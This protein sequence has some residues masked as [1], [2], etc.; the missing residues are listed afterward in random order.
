MNIKNIFTYII[1][2]CSIIIIKNCYSQNPCFVCDSNNAGFKATAF[3]IG[4]DAQGDFSFSSGFYS[5]SIGHSSISMGAYSSAESMNAV[6][7]G[8]FCKA[9]SAGYAFGQH[10]RA[11]GEPSVAIGHYV[12]ANTSRSIVIGSCYSDNRLINDRHN[13]LMVGFLSSYPTLFVGPTEQGQDFG[14]VGIGTKDPYTT[15]DV[16]GGVL[17]K[18]FIYPTG[19]AHEG[20]VLKSDEFGKADWA[21]ESPSL[22]TECLIG[23]G[24]YRKEGNVGI[25]NENPL[26]KLML[27]H[28]WTFNINDLE[29]NQIGYNTLF[30]GGKY[31]RLSSG[32]GSL[33]SFEPSG[34]ISIQHV[35]A[36][37]VGQQVDP[38][39]AVIFESTGNVGIGTRTPE[40]KLDV[41]G[42]IK[43]N[44]FQLL[45]ETIEQGFVLRSNYD[46]TAYWSNPDDLDDGDWYV[47]DNVLWVDNKKIGLGNSNPSEK[48]HIDGN[49]AITGDIL[50]Y[51]TS[52]KP[53]GIYSGS[54]SDDGASITLASNYDNTGSIK[55]FCKGDNGRIEFHNKEGQVM[56]LRA[57]NNVVLGS[58]DIQ[59]DMY[60]NGTLEANK[61]RVSTD[62]WW[63]DVFKPGY[64][65]L[66]LEQ[67]QEYIL[68]NHHLP[69]IPS[70]QEVITYGI[71]LAEMNALLVKKIEELTLYLIEQ[72]R[73][74]EE[75]RN[76]LAVY[77]H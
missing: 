52:W 70:E 51:R 27:G 10:A 14:R 58:P 68:T 75:L 35:S 37:P 17:C 21:P 50:G 46:G 15:L 48:L 19:N 74:I 40:A 63:D 76:R 43:T 61:V 31:Y 23:D 8:R 55:L 72:D 38:S 2:I 53:L 36:G 9:N 65:L 33:L 29:I 16:N 4:C 28:L 73:K 24:I 62:Y 7:I 20:Y 34:A 18:E 41:N 22:W 56:S 60:V 71:N 30:T 26:S 39:D 54:S 6:A 69:E 59:V 32:P 44:E 66:P 67:L 1:I 5:S 57:D 11:L 42:R 77:N 25:G 45:T 13:S 3:G 47:N 49:T 64:N 12:G